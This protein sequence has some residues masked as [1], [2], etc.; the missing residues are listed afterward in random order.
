MALRGDDDRDHSD[1]GLLARLARVDTPT[2]HA[3]EIVP[4]SKLFYTH[5]SL[6]LEAAQWIIFPQG[7]M[8]VRNGQAWVGL[9]PG[10]R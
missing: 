1:E 3:L 10:R 9:H 7:A 2:C 8:G 4:V 5:R 6:S